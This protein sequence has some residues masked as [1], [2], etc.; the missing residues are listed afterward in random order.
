MSPGGRHHAGCP[1]RDPRIL[2]QALALACS[3]IDAFTLEERLE[4]GRD[5]VAFMYQGFITTRHSHAGSTPAT[6]FVQP[7][8]LRHRLGHRATSP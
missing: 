2:V 6:S 5:L 7:P 1:V 3:I 4:I 8:W